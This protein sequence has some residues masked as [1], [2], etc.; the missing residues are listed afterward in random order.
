M[1]KRL[2]PALIFAILM[3]LLIF[4]GALAQNPTPLPVT[5]NDNQVN[6]VAKELFCPVCE[7]IPLDVCPTQACTQ[8]RDLIRLRLSEGWS[9]D[10]I[11][12]YFAQQYGDRVLGV[13]PAVGLNLLVY[14]LPPLVILAGVFVVV[15]VLRPGKN[16]AVLTPPTPPAASADPYIRQL[17]E[18]LKKRK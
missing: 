3:A 18:E 15:R 5:V 6:E 11:K 8:W 12:S 14:I 7:N 16:P 2:I 4:G 17:E 13:P 10:Q 9:K 1:L